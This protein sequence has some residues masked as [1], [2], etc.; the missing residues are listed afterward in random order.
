MH[1]V[2]FT[3]R[4]GE[5]DAWHTRVS[6]AGLDPSPVIDRFWFRSIYFREPSGVLFE[7]ATD[8]PGF[9][10]DEDLESLGQ[11]LT[12]PPSFEHRR[13]EIEAAL[14]PLPPATS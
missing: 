1:H 11:K 8:G 7:L 2:A 3:T 5:E 4:L 14:T 6:R 12:L 13:G 9:T 10:A